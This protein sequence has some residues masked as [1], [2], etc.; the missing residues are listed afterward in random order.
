MV[1]ANCKDRAV[2]STRITKDGVNFPMLTADALNTKYSIFK[3]RL[4]N[5]FYLKH[6]FP[7]LLPYPFLISI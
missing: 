5:M 7:I 1:S 2:A 3:Q 4:K 6:Y